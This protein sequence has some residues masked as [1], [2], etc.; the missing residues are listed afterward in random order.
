MKLTSPPR[1][2]HPYPHAPNLVVSLSSPFKSAL[3]NDRPARKR[4]PFT[5]TEATAQFESPAAGGRRSARNP[6]PLK[7]PKPTCSRLSQAITNDSS[8]I[9]KDHSLRVVCRQRC[10]RWRKLRG[11]PA[12]TNYNVRREEQM[13]SKTS[14]HRP[15]QASQDSRCNLHLRSSA[16]PSLPA[17]AFRANDISRP[18]HVKR[19]KFSILIKYGV[20]ISEDHS[21]LHA[22]TPCMC[23][24]KIELPDGGTQ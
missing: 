22:C 7:T 18:S 6:P 16:Y 19:D 13:V 24:F 4:F 17:K 12:I 23:M 9:G 15:S 2:P 1:Q 3:P 8:Q 21:T 14:V 11:P 10:S 5:R 20:S